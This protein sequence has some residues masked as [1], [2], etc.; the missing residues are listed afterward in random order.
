METPSPR[1]AVRH[2]RKVQ[3]EPEHSYVRVRSGFAILSF[4]HQGAYM[5][6]FDVGNDLFA[7]PT[8]VSRCVAH[9]VTRRL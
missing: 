8:P 5:L 9:L 6:T 3:L 4:P 1:S 7:L 2:G